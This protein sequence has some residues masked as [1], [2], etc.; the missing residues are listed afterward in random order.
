MI[1]SSIREIDV[2]THRV[3][4][5]WVDESTRDD[6]VSVKIAPEAAELTRRSN[7]PLVPKPDSCTAAFIQRKYTNQNTRPPQ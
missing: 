5:G 7:S 1:R 4:L 3:D 6:E 2:I